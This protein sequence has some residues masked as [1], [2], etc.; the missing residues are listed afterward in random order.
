MWDALAA[1]T[2]IDRDTV[3]D[4]VSQRRSAAALPHQS[5][6]G[7]SPPGGT[8]ASLP[9]RSTAASSPLKRTVASSR[10]PAG[11]FAYV[12]VAVIGGYRRWISPLRM[13]ACRFEP[14]CSAY[15]LAAIHRFGALRGSYLALR[16]L[17]R[18][19]PYHRGGYDPVP[20][21]AAASTRRPERAGV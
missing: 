4:S 17:A 12:L 2:W 10:R 16:R 11:L 3:T 9:L 18:C 15:A 21:R 6:A 13:P 14:S 19:H 8:V 1:L 7:S 20:E 5:K